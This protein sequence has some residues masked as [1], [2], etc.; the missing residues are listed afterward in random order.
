MLHLPQYFS[1]N[2][3]SEVYKHMVWEAHKAFIRDYLIKHGAFLNKETKEPMNYFL[4][5]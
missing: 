3:N 2:C 5:F 4:K 1:S